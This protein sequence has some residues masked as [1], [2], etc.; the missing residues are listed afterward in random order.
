MLA[1]WMAS[2]SLSTINTKDGFSFCSILRSWKTDATDSDA[3]I[4]QSMR[5]RQSN[6]RSQRKGDERMDVLSVAI[7][8]MA[9][10]HISFVLYSSDA[11]V[12]FFVR[13]WK[14][15]KDMSTERYTY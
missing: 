2:L 7:K 15:M 6:L 3:N 1:F 12:R 11:G 4:T 10:S 9:H 14:M 5:I 8:R 13:K